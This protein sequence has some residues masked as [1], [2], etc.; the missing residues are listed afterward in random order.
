MTA[1]LPVLRLGGPSAPPVRL[2]PLRCADGGST[3][4]WP[5]RVV[6]SDDGVGLDVSFECDDPAPL[7]TLTARDAPLWEEDV[8]ELFIAPGAGTPEVYFEF[9][10][11]PLGALFDARVESPHGCREGMRVDRGWDCTGIVWSAGI[12]EPSAKWQARLRVPWEA[13]VVGGGPL[14]TVWRANFYRIKRGAVGAD[15]F[16]CWSPTLTSPAD[17]HRPHRFGRLERC[18]S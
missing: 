2:P 1:E 4:R 17:F 13:L 8:V 5:T 11:N 18:C 3:A 14:P 7:A 10:V 12:D 9:E 16:S 6:V 15:E